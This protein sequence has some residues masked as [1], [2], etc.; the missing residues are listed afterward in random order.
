[1]RGSGGCERRTSFALYVDAEKGSGWH[2]GTICVN[3]GQGYMISISTQSRVRA[4]TYVLSTSIQS[5]VRGVEGGGG[6]EERIYPCSWM[7]RELSPS[8]L[9]IYICVH[10]HIYL[11]NIGVHFSYSTCPGSPLP[12]LYIQTSPL[13]EHRVQVFVKHPLA[14]A[15]PPYTKSPGESY[16]R[17]PYL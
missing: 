10:I 11:F 13:R 6:A 1:M 4:G 9:F 17:E 16:L 5:S 7:V 3:A 14:T 15:D 12:A 8:H 2:A